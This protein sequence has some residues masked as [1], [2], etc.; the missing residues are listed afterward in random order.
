MITA[1]PIL[2]VREAYCFL[3]WLIY[4]IYKD[5]QTHESRGKLGG[6]TL[7]ESQPNHTQQNPS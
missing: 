1:P 2:F 4:I 5:K 6:G 7:H 3:R